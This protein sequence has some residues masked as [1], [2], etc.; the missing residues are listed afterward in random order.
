MNIQ[1][2]ISFIK[3]RQKSQL[4]KFAT[5]FEP[6][7]RIMPTKNAYGNEPKLRAASLTDAS[8]SF[9][10]FEKK[11]VT[12]TT[13]FLDYRLNDDEKP[14]HERARGT[15][16]TREDD[17][18][19]SLGTCTFSIITRVAEIRLIRSVPLSITAM[20]ISVWVFV[21]LVVGLGVIRCHC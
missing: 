3:R 20:F 10:P 19:R 12:M 7:R 4:F 17:C 2:T 8:F 6:S 11:V 9:F 13:R 15:S 14:R 21:C 18:A 5:S 16:L 1:K